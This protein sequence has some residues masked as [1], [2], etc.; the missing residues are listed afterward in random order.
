MLDVRRFGG[1]VLL[2]VALAYGALNERNQQLGWLVGKW[3]AEFSG[4]V[5]C[6]CEYWHSKARKSCLFF[7]SRVYLLKAQ[8]LVSMLK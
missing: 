5:V 4:K 2:L 8:F 1:G 3:R 7:E 6:K